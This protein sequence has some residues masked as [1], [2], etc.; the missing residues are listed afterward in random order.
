[1][2]GFNIVSE[3]FIPLKTTFN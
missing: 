3:R 1:M 2:N